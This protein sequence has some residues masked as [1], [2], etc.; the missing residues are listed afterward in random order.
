MSN[1]IMA[2]DQGTTSSRTILYNERGETL[3]M[4][5]EAFSCQYPTAGWVEQEAED[6]WRTQKN[7]ME[8]A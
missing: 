4:A 2:L 7:T 6:I 3:A 8:T 5:N 1:V